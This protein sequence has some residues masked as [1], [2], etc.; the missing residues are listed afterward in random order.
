MKLFLLMLLLHFVADYTLQGCLANM[1]QKSWWIEQ[2]KNHGFDFAKY[3]YDYVC[4]L[5]CHALYWTLITFAPI[6]F[7]SDL[8]DIS[9]TTIV[10]GNMTIH[11][12]I[13]HIKANKFKINLIVDQLLHLA[14]IFVTYEVFYGIMLWR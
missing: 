14:Q 3:K 1:K 10:I 2:C 7:F 8:S 9:I 12:V 11:A 13:D 4:S 5:I 6:I